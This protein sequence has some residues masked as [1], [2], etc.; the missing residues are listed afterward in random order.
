MSTLA[1]APADPPG[2]AS[3]LA[4]SGQYIWE[5]LANPGGHWTDQGRLFTSGTSSEPQNA[6]IPVNNPASGSSLALTAP[7]TISNAR[8]FFIGYHH[9]LQLIGYAVGITQQRFETVSDTSSNFIQTLGTIDYNGGWVE[10]EIMDHNRVR[11]RLRF[12]VMLEPNFRGR[13][14]ALPIDDLE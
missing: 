10:P 12:T 11:S 4:P 3:G 8:D 13:P 9:H 14:K 1:F 2:T 7:F 6:T 5:A